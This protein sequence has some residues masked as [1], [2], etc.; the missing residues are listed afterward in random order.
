M[1]FPLHMAWHMLLVA[2]LAPLAAAALR[3]GRFDP[4]RARPRAFS[5]LVACLVEFVVVW[6]W[7]APALHDAARREALWFAAEQASFTAAALYL[8]MAIL[9]GDPGERLARAGSGVIALVF[10]FAHMTMLGVV[11]ALA[12]RELYAHAAGP[13]VGQQLGGAMMILAGTVAYPVAALW[14]SRSLV[15]GGGRP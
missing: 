9:G 15:V 11:I 14:L 7:H 2:V 1:T 5:P 4:V 12:P 3:A 8:W 10:T 13:H 6:G